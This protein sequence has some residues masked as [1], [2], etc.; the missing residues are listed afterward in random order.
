MAR[1]LS[2]TPP[3]PLLYSALPHLLALAP[4]VP[5]EGNRLAQRSALERQPRVADG[6]AERGGSGGRRINIH[7]LCMRD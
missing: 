1:F 2:P 5:H 6:A 4:A 7:N 3:P